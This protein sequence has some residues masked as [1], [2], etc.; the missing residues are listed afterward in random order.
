MREHYQDNAR[1]IGIILVV[2]GHVLRGLADAGLL[3]GAAAGHALLLSDYA[4]YT[5]H[6]PLFFLL[7]GLN[8]PA[9]LH[10]SR[11]RFVRGKL[12]TIV[13]PYLLWSVLQGL[14]QWSVSRYANHPFSLASLA[15]IFWEP[16]GQFWFLY[17]LL[18][19]QLI[20][21][22]FV[23]PRIAER[24]E[25]SAMRLW[26][27]QAAVAGVAL[28]GIVLGAMTSWGI[29][30]Q[31]FVMLPFYLLGMLLSGGRL[32]NLLRRAAQM[33][34]GLAIAGLALLFAFLAAAARQYG[35]YDSVYALPAG[36]AG[37]LLTLLISYRVAALRRSAIAKGLRA[38]GAASM[39]IFLLHIFLTGGTRIALM[40]LGI[41]DTAV[42]LSLGVV[43]SVLVPFVVYRCAV[44]LR[45]AHFVGFTQPPR[46]RK[47]SVQRGVTA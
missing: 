34:A 25:P 29:V 8:A 35:S 41:D 47:S 5:F 11:I 3:P 2:Y 19:C 14:M 42:H 12:R 17:A 37:I 40:E 43:A 9:S 18:I 39:P 45:I 7:S 27:R 36:L 46:G 44:R 28:A 23:D 30:T 33:P 22:A 38:L 6:M 21:A 1:G 26:H 20:A 4:I 31:A 13:Y 24:G 15:R 32:R 10:R 16:F